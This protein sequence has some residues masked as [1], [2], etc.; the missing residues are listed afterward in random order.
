MSL[1]ALRFLACICVLPGALACYDS[2][3][4]QAKRNAGET[5]VIEEIEIALIRR[6]PIRRE[7]LTPE[8][9]AR[10]STLHKT[11][12]EIDTSS[13]GTWI[14]NFKRDVNPDHEIAIWERVAKAYRSYCSERELSIEAK[15]EVY[16][17]ALY[18]S[19]MSEDDVL[20][21]LQLKE[22]TELS[23]ADALEII[24]GF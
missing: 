12:A 13:L 8:Q 15:K 16:R 1:N 3:D 17:I 2:A 22:L 4:P 9:V 14:D 11:F 24:R 10:L 5:V 21:R 6:G 7:S 20:K 23:K 18:C 19:M